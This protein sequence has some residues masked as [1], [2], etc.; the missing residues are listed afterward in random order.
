MKFGS[1]SSHSNLK[2]RSV[3]SDDDVDDDEEE[4]NETERK[5]RTQFSTSPTGKEKLPKYVFADSEMKDLSYQ[6]IDFFCKIRYMY[7]RTF[8]DQKYGSE[9]FMHS[10]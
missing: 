7:W 2:T 5:A 9:Q 8:P 6:F 10:L 1:I 3:V 4:L